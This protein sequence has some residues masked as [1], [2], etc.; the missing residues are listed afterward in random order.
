MLQRRPSVHL[1]HPCGPSH[2]AGGSRRGRRPTDGPQA[3]VES[4]SGGPTEKKQN[5]HDHDLTRARAIRKGDR[6]LRAEIESRILANEPARDIARKTKITQ[7]VLAVYEKEYFTMRS[8]LDDHTFVMEKCFSHPLGTAFDPQDV[9]TF[10][11]HTAFTRGV[12]IL[13]ELIRGADWTDLR[14]I[15]LR[16]YLPHAARLSS[17]AM[18]EVYERMLAPNLSLEKRLLLSRFLPSVAELF[19]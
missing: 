9:G 10:W 12:E 17:A 4:P 16:A 3:S 7:R 19:S 5:R 15:G 6:L 18:S 13:D 1:T 14:N 11:R 8:R 2:T